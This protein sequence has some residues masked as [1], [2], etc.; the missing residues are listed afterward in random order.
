MNPYQK[1]DLGSEY[2]QGIFDILKAGKDMWLQSGMGLLNPNN[3]VYEWWNKPRDPNATAASLLDDPSFITMSEQLPLLD[4]SSVAGMTKVFHGSPHLFKNWDF[5][6]MGS[7]E[8]AQAYGHGG[9]FAGNKGVGQ[10]YYDALSEKTPPNYKGE[11][12]D[13]YLN[14]LKNKSLESFNKKDYQ[15]TDKIKEEIFVVEI[16]RNLYNK[17]KSDSNIPN[18]Y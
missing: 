17:Y 1:R 15:N 7:G 6:K 16:L 3:P 12:I 2:Q 4:P 10:Y 5:K 8:G 14:K 9:Y 13:D 11:N 18:L